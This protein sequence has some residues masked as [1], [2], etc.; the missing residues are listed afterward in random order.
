MRSVRA[1]TRI[2]PNQAAIVK[3]LRE[4]ATPA[5]PLTARQLA[6]A[7][8]LAPTTV[9]GALRAL[10]EHG[11]VRLIQRSAGRKAFVLAGRARAS[12]S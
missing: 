1:R 12:R 11:A 2:A 10:T 7:T 8:C 6:D 3:V 5:A 9:H 4:K